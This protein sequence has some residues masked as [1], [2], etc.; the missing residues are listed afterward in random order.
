MP[1]P[2]PPQ[3]IA[4]LDANPTRYKNTPLPD[5]YNP[6]QDILNE[7]SYRADIANPDPQGTVPKPLTN[8]DLRALLS[9]DSAGRLSDTWWYNMQINLEGE[10]GSREDAVTQVEAAVDRNNITAAE[11]TLLIDEINSTIPDPDWP[12]TVQD[13][14]DLMKEWDLG[15]MNGDFVNN[16]LGRV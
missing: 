11:G 6:T 2:T 12:P 9:D 8:G 7:L 16:S 13:D 10:E 14:S 3:F 5:G 15:G 4:F 1:Y